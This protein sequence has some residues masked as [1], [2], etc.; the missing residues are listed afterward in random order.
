MFKN[1]KQMIHD[2]E[3]VICVV[4]L[5]YVGLPTAIFFAE[6]GFD[7]IG[8]SIE[9]DKIDLINKG[10]SPIGELNLD[11]RL[12]KVINDGKLAAT[13]DLEDATRRSDVILMIVPTPVT[14]SKDPDLSH[15]ISAGEEVLKGLDKG[16]LV[17]LE[18]TVYPGVTEE[19]LQPILERSGLRAGHDFGLAYCPERY[20]PGDDDHTIENVARVVGGITPEWAEI[21]RDLYQFI[22]NEDIKVLRNI[23]TAEAA[24]VIENTQRDL[25]IALMNELAMI[26]EK[27]DIDVMDVIEGA[28]SKWNFNVYYPGAGVGGHCLPVDPYYLVKKS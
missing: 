4:G 5:G 22:I 21:T 17:V 8:I 10:I 19:T 24:K 26:F 23:R 13:S 2:K 27:L 14:E 6:M 15:I 11:S 1:L 18:S 25:N 28:R 20:N 12:S 9:D 16:K 7:V 3:S